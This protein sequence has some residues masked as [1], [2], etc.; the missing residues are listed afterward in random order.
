QIFAVNRST[1]PVTLDID[2][3]ALPAM[4]PN[5][6]ISLADD[7]SRKINSADAPERVAPTRNTGGT[8]VTLP[9]ISWHALSFEEQS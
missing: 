8:T 5:G 4:R 9:P 3:R 6:Q 2:L 7:D 1:E